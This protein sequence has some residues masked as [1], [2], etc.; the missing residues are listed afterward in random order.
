[1]PFL[2]VQDLKLYYDTTRGVVKA[3]DG[4][5]FNLEKGE[6]IGIVGES[7]CGKSSTANAVIR[8][9]PKN[10]YE[11]SGKVII[12]GQNIMDLNEEEF[13]KEIRWNT[14]AIVFQGAMNSLS[15]VLNIGFQVGEP[16]IIHENKSKNE[17]IK[18]AK[19]LF[20]LV[21][22]PEDFASRFPH[23]L[24]GGMKQRVV[25]TMA[26]VLNPSIL[27]LDEPTSA[28]DVSIQAQI[29]NLLKKLKRELGISMIFITHDIAL[30]S[31]LCDKLAVMYAGQLVELGSIEDILR[32]PKHPYSQKLLASI[33]L[34]RS[35]QKPEFI[36]G[37][38]PDLVELPIGCRFYERCPFAFEKCRLDNPPFLNIDNRQVR[39]WLYKEA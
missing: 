23:E 1:M 35:D 8:L 16:L 4:I 19:E 38:P 37:S 10:T 9:L 21:G 6:T 18:R 17:A 26:L 30:A 24:S 29:M 12:D 34:L 27:I 33:P 22:L 20:A 14:I 15:P 32:D 7:G 28:L 31:D 2:D 5:S 36:P 13:R 39:C 25:I 3:V 11:H